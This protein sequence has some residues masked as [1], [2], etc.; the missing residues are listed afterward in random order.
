[1][2]SF[3]TSRFAIAAALLMTLAAVCPVFA[4]NPLDQPRGLAL[5]AKGNLYVA[6]QGNNKIV[7]FNPNYVQLTSKTITT[8]LD[9]PS[10]V[11]IDTL[12]NI[13]VSNLGDGE[14]TIYSSTGAPNDAAT[15]EGISSPEGIT[16][17]GIGN[18]FVVEAYQDVRIY[19]ANAD[20]ASSVPVLV[21]TYSTGQPMFSVATHNQFFAWGSVSYAQAL[22]IDGTMTGAGIYTDP[23]ASTALALAYDGTGNLY[24]CN[25][26]NTVNY[27]NFA[28]GSTSQFV[29]LSFACEGVVVDAARQRI[30]MSNQQGNSIA[31]YSPNG[32]LL[33]TIE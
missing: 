8:G 17:D 14:V 2:K 1:M 22:S 11:A 13:Y 21:K 29:S 3:T 16:V 20:P 31:V 7:V 26:N 25:T 23:S 4:A 30:Y 5:D 19:S 10:G 6:N 12:G 28:T 9:V 18:I 32:T 27:M 24:I 15:I 33:K